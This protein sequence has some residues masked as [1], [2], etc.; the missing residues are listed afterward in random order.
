MLQVKLFKCFAVMKPSQHLTSQYLLVQSN[1]RITI[2]SCGICSKLMKR[3]TERQQWGRSVV[4][5]DFKQI[6]QLIVK[7]SKCRLGNLSQNTH[8][9]TSRKNKQ[10]QLASPKISSDSFVLDVVIFHWYICSIKGKAMLKLTINIRTTYKI[11]HSQPKKDAS[12]K[13]V[14]FLD[15]KQIS[16]MVLIT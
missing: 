10:K 9:K 13:R 12:W 16:N 15:G 3:R 11:Y 2:K 5:V 14:I 4:F 6:S 7:S 1:N 8:I